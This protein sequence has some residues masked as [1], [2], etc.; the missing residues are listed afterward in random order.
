MRIPVT[1]RSQFIQV[2]ASSNL[3]DALSALGMSSAFLEKEADL[4]GISPDKDL[5]VSAVEH[6]VHVAV[7]EKGAEAAAAT[8]VVANSFSMSPPE[9]DID[10]P[11]LFA[12]RDK[13]PGGGLLFLGSVFDPQA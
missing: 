5:F 3:K 2:T 8:A 1:I 10:R 12:I 7:D 11:F 4:S 9:I 13:R 6:K